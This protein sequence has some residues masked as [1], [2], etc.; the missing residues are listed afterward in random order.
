MKHHKDVVLENVVLR[1]QLAIHERRGHRAKLEPADRRFWSV[2]ARGW[3]RWRSHVQIVQPA[4]VVGWHRSAWRSYWRWKSRRP[5]PGR[6][7]IDAETRALITRLVTENSTWGV[8]RI[9]DE[10]KTLGISVSSVTVHR[11]VQRGRPPS[12]SWQTFLRLHA[13]QIWACDFFSV[14]TLTFGTFYVFLVIG[15]ERRQIEHWNVTRHPSAQWVWRQIIAATPWGQQPRYL[16]GVM[17]SGRVV[18][19]LRR[20]FKRRRRDRPDRASLSV[21]LRPGLGGDCPSQ[22]FAPLPDDSAHPTGA[23]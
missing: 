1:Q 6:P 23:S 15:H 22:W 9:A 3:V 10:L 12:P 21:K 5:R 18:L 7:R 14:Q 11:Y 16:W 19:Q 20:G 13:R 4:T 2:T 8:R 17:A